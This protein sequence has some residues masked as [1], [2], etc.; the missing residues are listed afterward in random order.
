[1]TFIFTSTKFSP[2]KEETSPYCLLPEYTVWRP[3]KS[4]MHGSCM[5]YSTRLQLKKSTKSYLPPLD[6]LRRHLPQYTHFIAL[7]PVE[8]SYIG[9][10]SH[11]DNR[12][13]SSYNDIN[14]NNNEACTSIGSFDPFIAEQH[15]SIDVAVDCSARPTSPDWH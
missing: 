6:V 3:N 10:A 8:T 7:F 13:V 15:E 12:S 4:S 2:S 11:L 14:N 1:M 9:L 5:R